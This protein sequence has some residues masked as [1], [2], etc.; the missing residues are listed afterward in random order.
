MAFN[1]RA[2]KEARLNTGVKRRKARRK[3]KKDISKNFIII[4]ESNNELFNFA[5]TL[6]QTS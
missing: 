4:S 5:E 3:K 6:A 1:S 2:L